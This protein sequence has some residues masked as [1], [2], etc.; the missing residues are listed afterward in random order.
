MSNQ[1][2]VAKV[3]ASM[4]QRFMTKVVSEFGQGVGELDFAPSQRRLAQNYFIALDGVLQMAEAKRLKKVEK[5]R[6]AVPVTWQ[7]I[8]MPML[9]RSVVAAARIGWDPLERNHI[10]M[11]PYLNGTTGQYDIGFIPGY[12]GIELKARKYALDLPDHVTVELVYSSDKIKIFKKDRTN[13]VET[14]SLEIQNHFDRGEVVGGFYYHEFTGRPEK[15]KIVVMSLKNIL[16]RKPKYASAE[17][18]GGEKDVWEKDPQTGRNRKAGTEH[19]DGWFEEM[20]L[21]TIYRAAYSSITIDSQKIDGAY[22]DLQHSEAVLRDTEA[23][24]DYLSHANSQLI[25]LPPTPEPD[26][27][28]TEKPLQVDPETGEIIPHDDP[29]FREPPPAEDLPP[30]MQ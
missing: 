18:W 19:T 28:A 27:S 14:Y 16:K 7:H 10:N 13:Q 26:P 11:I 2:A 15:N 24:N 25:E 1:N 20:C 3:E 30:F 8:N 22:R 23:D 9:A 17:F 4:S 21:K 6:E 12:R 5:Y 29:A